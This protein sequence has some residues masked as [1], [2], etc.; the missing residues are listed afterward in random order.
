MVLLL[1]TLRRVDD[2]DTDTE[3]NNSAGKGSLTSPKRVFFEKGPK[4]KAA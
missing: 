4:K 3:P 1:L 2:L